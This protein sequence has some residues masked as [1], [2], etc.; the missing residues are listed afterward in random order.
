MGA[1]VEA[2]SSSEFATIAV[3]RNDS[4]LI[5]GLI[6]DLCYSGLFVYR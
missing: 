2:I 4:N 6:C 5:I 1:L 3:N